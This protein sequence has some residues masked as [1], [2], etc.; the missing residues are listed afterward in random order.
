MQLPC[1]HRRTG[2][3]HCLLLTSSD[4]QQRKTRSCR[5][6]GNVDF[7]LNYTKFYEFLLFEVVDIRVVESGNNRLPDFSLAFVGRFF[8]R[9]VEN[10]LKSI[11]MN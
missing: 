7:S 2:R 6:C 5:A 4:K 1:D 11:A 10:V 3:V 8:V 9:N